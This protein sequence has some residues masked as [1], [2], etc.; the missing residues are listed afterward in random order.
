[1]PVRSEAAVALRVFL[2]HGD[3]RSEVGDLIPFE[4]R[5]PQF[6]H[7]GKRRDVGDLIVPQIE[8]LDPFESLEWGKVGHLISLE[9]ERG[10][11]V[12][13]GQRLERPN[14][15]ARQIERHHLFEVF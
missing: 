3:Q 13:S 4:H 15:V 12:H 9:I 8:R 6:R 10:E 5:V 14:F 2:G 7:V 11:L 1:M